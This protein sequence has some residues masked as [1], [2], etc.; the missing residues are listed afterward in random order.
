MASFDLN[1][2][3]TAEAVA[4]VEAESGGHTYR[5]GSWRGWQDAAGRRNANMHVPDWKADELDR[6]VM[7]KLLAKRRERE[8]ALETARAD[9]EARAERAQA[10]ADQQREYADALRD[11]GYGGGSGGGGGGGGRRPRPG[12]RLAAEQPRYPAGH[13]KAGQFR[14]LT[15]EEIAQGVGGGGGDEEGGGGGSLWQSRSPQS[16]YSVPRHVAN[17]FS[18]VVGAGAG[19]ATAGVGM[20]LSPLGATGAGATQVGSAAVSLLTAGLNT[21]ASAG[22]AVLS[23]ALGGLLATAVGGA[24]A[25]VLSAVGDLFGQIAQAITGALQGLVTVIRDLFRDAGQYASSVMQMVYVGGWGL[26]DATGAVGAFG[27]LG[28]SPEQTSGM[29]GQWNM[30]PEFLGARLGA[31]GGLQRD[32]GGEVDWIGTLRGMRGALGSYPAMAQMPV[33]QGL[34]GAQAGAQLM[35]MMQMDPEAFERAV[36]GAEALEAPTEQLRA[37]REE[38]APMQAQVALLATVLKTEL[39]SAALEPILGLLNTLLELVRENRGAISEWMAALPERLSGWIA[40]AT[41]WIDRMADS[42]PRVA[43]GLR[44]VVDRL[45]ATWDTVKRIGEFVTAHPTL[46]AMLAVGALGALSGGVPGMISGAALGG[47]IQVGA[48]VGGVGGG[49]YG[50]AAGL[51]GSA[52][53]SRYGGAGLTAARGAIGGMMAGGGSLAFPLGAGGYGGLTRRA[54]GAFD[55]DTGRVNG[56]SRVD[57]WLVGRL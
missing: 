19:M 11:A 42:L 46:S 1:D 7:D 44:S 8:E 15:E 54:G 45:E 32:E 33:L 52:L 6:A 57:K 53:L 9:E 49:V 56:D 50:G 14:P 55:R 43:E 23:L 25:V 34:M 20:A 3:L 16:E 35:P 24:A 36:A 21:A 10:E 40:D 17:L 39:A 18:R 30:R 2:D 5:S 22:S 51:V 48:S 27:A 4:E 47:G 28:M 37:L 29:L 38:L 31:L 13:E 12:R 41:R 26:G